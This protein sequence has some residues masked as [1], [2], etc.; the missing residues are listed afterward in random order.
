[1]K[2][3]IKIILG[4]IILILALLLVVSILKPI[5]FNREAEK[6]GEAVKTKLLDIRKAQAA[7]KN[8]YGNYTSSFD[9]LIEFVKN[10]SF[11]IRK[12]SG[13]YPP[14][15]M[16]EAEALEAGVISV[17]RTLVSV[18][19]SLFI[20]NNDIEN[21]R[22]IPYLEDEEFVM[23]AGS[24]MTGSRV[25]V[26]VFE[27]YVLYETLFWDMDKQLVAGYIVEKSRSS[28][29]PGLKLGSMTEAVITG[30]WE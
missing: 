17:A 9:T 15:E 2:G 4:V 14:D 12:I 29:F 23:D 22:Y 16:N 30:N 3:F 20:H 8:I 27:V 25:E 6:R 10:D 24:I 13:T 5:R 19:D 21:M 28:G 26:D 11:E 1:M 7:Y 18:K